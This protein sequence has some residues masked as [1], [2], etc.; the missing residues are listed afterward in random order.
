MKHK[1][2]RSRNVPGLKWLGVS[3]FSIVSLILAYTQSAKI[4]P[5]VESNTASYSESNS[6]YSDILVDRVVDGDTLKLENEEKV[7]LIGIDTPEM[8]ESNKLHRDSKR[9]GQDVHTI[10]AMGKKSYQFTRQLVEGKRVKLEFDVERKDKY[11][12]LL[13]YVYL[14]DGTFI[15]AEIVKQGFASLM[16]YPPNV[17][18]ADF[19]QKLYRQARENK[20]GLW[21]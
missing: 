4:K 19:F 7:R 17:K 18:Y 14:A 11:G 15:N 1:I 13:A 9:S 8:H 21:K 6:L 12:R 2:R 5:A 20:L 10:I 3:L 16:T